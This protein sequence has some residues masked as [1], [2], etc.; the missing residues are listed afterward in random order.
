MRKTC[1]PASRSLLC[2]LLLLAPPAGW[3]A[4]APDLFEG[5][6]IKPQPLG[7]EVLLDGKLLELEVELP[8]FPAAR[9]ADEKGLLDK[10]KVKTGW[11]LLPET[12]RRD[13]AAFS[14][15]VVELRRG[16]L[17]PDLDKAVIGV[18]E[19]ARLD[20]EGAAKLD[21]LAES[22]MN[23]SLRNWQ[24]EFAER[25]APDLLKGDAEALLKSWKPE[26]FTFGTAPS[27]ISPA[28][29]DV[30][31]EGL[32]KIVT[33]E[34][35]AAAEAEA[36]AA[37]E[38]AQQAAE[39]ILTEAEKGA[40][41]VLSTAMDAEL[42]SILLNVELDEAREKALRKAAEDA[43]KDTLKRW[44]ERAEKRMEEMDDQI[45]SQV[46]RI[47][48]LGVG[49]PEAAGKPQDSEIWRTAR[50]GVLTENERQSI[51]EGQ[52][53]IKQRRAEA[54]AM[55]MLAEV[56]QQV[57]FSEAQREKL[58]A[59]GSGRFLSFEVRTIGR[60][61]GDEGIPDPGMMLPVLQG[62]PD[63]SLAAVLDPGQTARW[64]AVSGEDLPQRYFTIRSPF[65]SDSPPAAGAEPVDELEASR[66][67][68]LKLADESVKIKEKYFSRIQGKVENLARATALPPETTARLR[69]AGK[70]AA[71]Q[72][73]Q[74]A[75]GNME[76]NL[77]N[78]VRGV[79]PAELPDRLAKISLFNG[80]RERIPQADPPL[81]EAAL[82]R[83][84]TKSQR[85]IW[86]RECRAGQAWRRRA[87]SA[88][89]ASG[90]ERHVT[91]SP[92]KSALL[93]EKLEGVLQKYES[94]INNMMSPG[95]QYQSFYSAIPVA[96]LTE[97]DMAGIFTP[98]QLETVRTR[99]LGQAEQF[100]TMIRRRNG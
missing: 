86:Q 83:L 2:A 67:I 84:L 53:R 14:E 33:A 6:K 31:K 34:Y 11:A 56:D 39:R 8:D 49:D 77:M 55:T 81:W 96:L 45:L 82:K 20:A 93:L 29:T 75:V 80:Y 10:T 72:L 36:K 98:K 5:E 43:V 28:R 9:E 63:D 37:R 51:A 87:L 97:K 18:K 1:L 17:K 88:F 52:E 42:E 32:R 99:C 46:Q 15:K 73:A 7:D 19:K 24:A 22:A 94:D 61:M 40:G 26:Q 58:L 47:E 4:A 60:G 12:I 38:E 35:Y 44:R 64:K 74:N 27:P 76:Q 54:L 89:V 85:E 90:V 79:K 16:E 48:D 21:A 92:E 95:W 50:G 30:W 41:G 3:A 23:E 78:Q 91:L 69:T 70:G 100:A 62:I 66:L 59:L 71:E 13:F 25:Y 57:G 65:G 68:T